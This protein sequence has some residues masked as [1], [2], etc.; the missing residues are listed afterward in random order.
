[1]SAEIT[2]FL[3]RLLGALILMSFL[4]ALFL[5]IWRSLCQAT[6]E[7]ADFPA[8]EEQELA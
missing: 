5:I 1:M 6:D 3:L 2:I 8:G 4:L 7:I